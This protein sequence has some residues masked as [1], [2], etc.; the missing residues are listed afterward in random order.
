MLR[1]PPLSW[2]FLAIK[3]TVASGFSRLGISSF[4][5]GQRLLYILQQGDSSPSTTQKFLND[6]YHS[7]GLSTID[8]QT[9]FP[10]FIRRHLDTIKMSP[11]KLLIKIAARLHLQPPTRPDGFGQ[12][13]KTNTPLSH[14]TARRRLGILNNEVL[15]LAISNFSSQGVV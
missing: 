11:T 3:P 2:H 14:Y 5:F 7:T 10:L 12:T 1:Q 13:N 15:L 8:E 4:T 6:I 9:I